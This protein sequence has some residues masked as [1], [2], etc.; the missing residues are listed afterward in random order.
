[1][2]TLNKEQKEMLCFWLTCFVEIHLKFLSPSF[3]HCTTPPVEVNNL[4]TSTRCSVGLGTA[5]NRCFFLQ[6][7]AVCQSF[8]KAPG[9]PSLSATTGVTREP[10]GMFSDSLTFLLLLSYLLIALFFFVFFFFF[11][12]FV[13]LLN[14]YHFNL[15]YVD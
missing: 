1:M 14:F 7:Q 2:C 13:V 12:L 8:L 9:L 10:I 3:H 5:G 6:H 15:L 4:P 11:F